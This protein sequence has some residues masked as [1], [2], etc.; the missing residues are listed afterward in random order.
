MTYLATYKSVDDANRAI[1]FLEK[2]GVSSQDIGAASMT[3][4]V[5]E[6]VHTDNDNAN[7]AVRVASET[8]GGILSGGALGGVVGVLTGLAALAIPGFGA[9]LI[10]GPLAASL[11]LSGLAANTVTGAA[12]GG[13][14]GGVSGLV[15]SLVSKGVSREDAQNIESTLKDKGVLVSVEGEQK[16][17]I[18]DTH[19]VSIISIEK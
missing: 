13:A 4:E 8:G 2:N 11:G 10:S 7:G 9:L 5:Q 6:Q 18:Q 12:I 1:A 16:S 3:S 14:V 19:P 17:L 15:H